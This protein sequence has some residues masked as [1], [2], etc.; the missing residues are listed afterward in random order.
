MEAL[1]GIDGSSGPLAALEGIDGSSGPLAVL[2][3]G[4]WKFFSNCHGLFK[5][6]RIIFW[7]L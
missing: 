1:E 5:Y 4:K 2:E 3:G 6:L 7:P